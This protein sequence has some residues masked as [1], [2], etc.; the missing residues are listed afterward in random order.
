M[1]ILHTAD[2]HIGKKLHGIDLAPDLALFFD[3]MIELISKEHIEVLLVSG[4]IF[5]YSNPSNEAKKQYYQVLQRLIKLNCK[6]IITGGNH[7]SPLELNAPQSLLKMLD[8]H[9]VGRL[10]AEKRQMLIPILKNGEI[11]AVVAAVP[12]IRDADLLSQVA[13]ASHNDYQSQIRAGIAQVF[14]DVASAAMETYPQLPAVAMGHLFAVG[15]DL[16]ESEREIQVGNMAG[17]DAGHFGDYFSYVAL[18]H[19]H[20]P[21]RVGKTEHIQYSGS[22]VSLSFSEREDKKRV[23]VIEIENHALKDIRSVT[24]PSFRSLRSI[25]GSYAD[26]KDKLAVAQK[27]A[28]TNEL[29]A[30]LEVRLE[31]SDYDPGLVS[32]FQQ[33]CNDSQSRHLIIAR[34]QMTFKNKVS[35]LDQLLQPD[36]QADQLQPREIFELMLENQTGEDTDKNLIREAFHELYQELM[37]EDKGGVL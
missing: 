4:D 3:W 21:Q 29:P 23:I 32:N 24:V 33:L 15:A 11:Q 17:I 28:K 16:S 31:E 8:I 5:D 37:Q 14:A 10:P 30:L 12:F 9:V 1:K 27:K 19:I 13:E 20:R 35:G 18:G 25:S 36:Q 2:W 34:Q 6:V 26:I 22:P 7:D